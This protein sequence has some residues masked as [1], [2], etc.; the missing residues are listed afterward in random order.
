[1]HV[2]ITLF[3]TTFVIT[4]KFSLVCTKISGSCIF[5]LIFP[6][7]SSG[8]NTFCVKTKNKKGV[9]FYSKLFGNKHCRYTTFCIQRV[10]CI[11]NVHSAIEQKA[12]GSN[13]CKNCKLDA[14]RF[15]Q[16]EKG[17]GLVSVSK[18]RWASINLQNPWRCVMKPLASFSVNRTVYK[19]TLHDV[20]FLYY[21]MNKRK[22][23][24]LHER[25]F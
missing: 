23:R 24:Q 6:F 5:S 9:Q 7:Y 3:I 14:I 8:K 21:C 2:Q 12:A 10:L 11:Q 13:G 25:D 18:A 17:K 4:A 20:M 16:A 19:V 15:E 1:M 22:L